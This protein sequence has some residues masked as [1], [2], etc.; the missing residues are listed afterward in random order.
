MQQKELDDNVHVDISSDEGLDGRSVLREV[1]VREEPRA[2][3]CGPENASIQHF[4][5]PS[6]CGQVGAKALGVLVLVL[7]LVC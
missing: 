2:T 3:C 5:D 4:H 1:E 6:H 7:C